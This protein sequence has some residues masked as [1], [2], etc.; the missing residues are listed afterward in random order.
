MMSVSPYCD[1]RGP[2][3]S[4]SINP[5]TPNGLRYENNPGLVAILSTDVNREGNSADVIKIKTMKEKINSEVDVME[6]LNGTVDQA[7][8]FVEQGR[9]CRYKNTIFNLSFTVTFC[10]FRFDSF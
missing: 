3:S 6:H 5:S 4:P 9:K 2:A 7:E 8:E 10:T 1:A